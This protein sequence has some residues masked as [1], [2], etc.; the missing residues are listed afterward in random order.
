VALGGSTLN[1]LMEVAQL[2]KEGLQRPPESVTDA[3]G[4]EI[5]GTGVKVVDD[6]VGIDA[7]DRGG[8]AAEDI[9]GLRYR[10]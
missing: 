10:A 2:R 7:D 8:D 4:Q 3:Q 5:F 6:P 9:G 1:Q